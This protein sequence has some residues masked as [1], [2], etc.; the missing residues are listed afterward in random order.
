MRYAH[1]GRK[2][3]H[4]QQLKRA[5]RRVASNAAIAGTGPLLWTRM[6]CSLSIH[7]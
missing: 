2:Q 3:H 7:T 4:R 1:S 5:A 6:A